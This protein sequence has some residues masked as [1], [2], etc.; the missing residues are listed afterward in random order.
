MTT[1]TKR[2]QSV[3]M[4]A[5]RWYSLISTLFVNVAAVEKKYHVVRCTTVYH[6]EVFALDHREITERHV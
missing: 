4:P 5:E 1:E 6:M 3:S 2:W